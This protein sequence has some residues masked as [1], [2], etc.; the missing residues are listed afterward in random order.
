MVPVIKRPARI[1]EIIGIA[2][3]LARGFGFVRA[4]LYNP[5]GKR[6][7]FGGMPFSPAAERKPFCPRKFDVDLGTLR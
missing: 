3:T 1:K 6:I 2:E 5:D 4:D 7:L